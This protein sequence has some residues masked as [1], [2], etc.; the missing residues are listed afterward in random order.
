[1]VSLRQGSL[2]LRTFCRF[3]VYKSIKSLPKEG[4]GIL[5]HCCVGVG[6]GY[7]KGGPRPIQ[8]QANREP[9]LVLRSL[10]P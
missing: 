3:L 8:P 2:R 4:L 5:Q 6:G 10:R 9:K 7:A 1:M